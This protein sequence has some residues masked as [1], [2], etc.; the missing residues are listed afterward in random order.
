LLAK[1]VGVTV[2]VPR[3]ILD[4]REM[5]HMAKLEPELEVPR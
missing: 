2:I 1:G 4:D 5:M 3:A